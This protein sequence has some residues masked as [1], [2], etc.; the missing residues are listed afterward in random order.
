M[1]IIRQCI[2]IYVYKRG[3]E[4]T[5]GINIKAKNGLG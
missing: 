2:K 1:Y 5:V 4:D 3:F